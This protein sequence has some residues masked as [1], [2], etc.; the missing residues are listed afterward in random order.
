MQ[1]MRSAICFLAFSVYSL[2]SFARADERTEDCAKR[3]LA[4]HAG[5][6]RQEIEA[7]ATQDGGLMGALKDER[8][9]LRSQSVDQSGKS[10]MVNI[11]FHPVGLSDKIYN[12]ANL[13]AKWFKETHLLQ[14]PKDIAVRVSAPFLDHRHVD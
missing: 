3:A 14:N 2:A 1:L 9:I 6:T 5:L 7:K 11:D 13:F 12:D 4:I 8:F 10:C